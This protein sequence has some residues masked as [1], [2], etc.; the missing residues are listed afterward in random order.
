MRSLCTSPS[1][2]TG[3]GALGETG[4]SC[5]SPYYTSVTPPATPLLLF[6]YPLGYSYYSPVT[7]MLLLCYPS[8]IPPLRVHATLIVFHKVRSGVQS[9]SPRPPAP[10]TEPVGSPSP[11]PGWGCESRWGSQAEIPLHRGLSVSGGLSLAVTGR[12]CQINAG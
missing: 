7:P 12:E 10:P 9:F 5:Y 3:Q 4:P 11:F 6:R 1:V 8:V 2:H